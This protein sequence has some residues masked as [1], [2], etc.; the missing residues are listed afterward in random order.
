MNTATGQPGR[1]VWIA[2]ALLLLTVLFWSGNVVTGRALRDAVD[3]IAL[4]LYRWTIAGL[5]LLAL[6]GRALWRHRR[7]A[8]NHWPVPL[9]LGLTGVVGYQTCVYVAL[10]HTQ[11]VNALLVLQLAPVAIVAGARWLYGERVGPMRAV[12]MAVAALGALVLIARGDPGVI[13]RL[14]LNAGDATMLLAVGFWAG[15]SLLLKQRPTDL[16]PMALLLASVLVG[17]AVLVPAYLL[18]GG[19]ATRPA[20]PPAAW[21][22]VGYIGVFASFFAFLFW[23]HGV[24]R[25]G[26]ARASVFLYL[27]PVFGAVLG[28]LLLNERLAPY[29]LLGALL[30]LGGV[31]LMNR[32]KS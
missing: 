1:G 24:A 9:G 31:A 6:S 16:P 10:H 20:L 5:L 3:P 22:G 18:S 15:Y 25:V 26:P 12:G 23:N 17:L 14:E 27:M 28:Y 13:A 32:Q 8:L 4:N 2:Y 29:H 21:V 11:A 7:V 19:P 30:V